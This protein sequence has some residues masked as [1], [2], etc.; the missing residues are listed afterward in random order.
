M[1]QKQYALF[2]DRFLESFA[3]SSIMGD[4]K[5]SIIELIANA[6]DAGATEV[7]IKWPENDGDEF[8]IKDN[9]HGMT[10]SQF[11][12]RFRT[13]AYNRIREQGTSAEI[14]PDHKNKIA[15][16]PTFG[17]N[18]KGRLGG[19]AFGEHYL[20]NTSR[21]G[22]KVSYKVSRDLT[23]SLAFQKIGD[24]KPI[25]THG[26]E[27]IIANAIQTGISAEDAR[28]EIGMRFLTDPNFKV[29]L[30]GVEISFADIPDEHMH[31]IN[32]LVDGVGTIKILMIDVQATDKTTQQH[33]IAWHV[34]RRLVGE[35]TWKGSGSE[36]LIDG[37]RA[38]AKR[39]IFI[40]QAD[41]L[42][43][44]V[45]PDWTAFLQTDPKWKKA[46]AAVHDTI[47]SQLLNYSKTQREETFQSVE[48]ANRT[49][50]S[51]MGIVSREK[52]EKFIKNIQEECPSINTDDLEKVGR[53]LANL[54]NT[55]SKYSLIHA[56]ATATEE[57]LE[58]LTEILGKWDID[59]AKIVLDEIEYR[60]TLLENLQSKVLSHLTDEVQELQPLFH[61]GLWIF[62]PEYETIEYTSNQ[63]MTAVIQELFGVPHEQ[64]SRNRPDFAILPD[65]TVGLYGLS[66]YDDQGAEIGIDRLTIVELKKPGI[67]ISDE[68]KSQAWKY[69]SELIKKGLIRSYT[70]VICFVLGSEI[71]P[72]EAEPRTELSGRVLIQPLDYDTVI[73]RAKSRLLNL[74]E[75]IKKSPF[76][77]ETRA[78]MYMAE[79]SQ[80]SLFQ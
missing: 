38:A 20:V 69:V 47:K 59:L 70:H 78:R 30:N 45:A 32:V 71:I 61:R 44:S 48:D 56:L 54:E 49:A 19:F 42:E 36:H 10:E 12:K 27:I 79:K 2:D 65:G 29:S 76:L 51:K 18:G 73:R 4:P 26:T 33:G 60:T 9:G 11:Q 39:F 53:L 23:H 35:C 14:P 17:R 15:L 68:Q 63:G 62:G 57:E 40:V 41:A 24:G 25:L 64:G 6:W 74:H 67:P 28:K 7:I 50:L 43:D 80:L 3:G 16:R 77:Q 55:E 5:I 58:N 72:H 66:K 52:W 13:L 31:E 8:S 34:K 21:D 37:R 22:Q 46:S 75:K 1:S